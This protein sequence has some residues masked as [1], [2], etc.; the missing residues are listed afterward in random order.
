LVSC[1]G[2]S[3]TNSQISS[4]NALISNVQSTTAESVKPSAKSVLLRGR[5]I[6]TTKGYVFGNEQIVLVFI[7]RVDGNFAAVAEVS[8][9]G[10]FQ[11][12]ITVGNYTLTL[13][14]ADGIP[15]AGNPELIV[16]VS[17]TSPVQ[18]EID[19]DTETRKITII[20][21]EGCKVSKLQLLDQD[22]D[23][24]P[25]K[26]ENKLDSNGDGKLDLVE[27][28]IKE[29]NQIAY[30]QQQTQGTVNYLDEREIQENWYSYLHSDSYPVMSID[31][32]I[33]KYPCHIVVEIDNSIPESDKNFVLKY[34][35]KLCSVLRYLTNYDP[36]VS[37]I[38]SYD[39]GMHRSWNNNLTHLY[40]SVL[41]TEDPFFKSWYSVELAHL[42]IVHK[43]FVNKQNN[44]WLYLRPNET[45]SQ[46]LTSVVA[47]YYGKQL[48]FS[49]E[50]YKYY[51]QQLKPDFYYAIDN[52]IRNTNPF[53]IYQTDVN[54][55]MNADT[56]SASA[57]QILT[58]FLADPNFFKNL[59]GTS[60][61]WSS[62]ADLKSDF[63]RSVETLPYDVLSAYVNNMP[64]FKQ[65]DQS[66]RPK[67]MISVVLR[68]STDTKSEEGY[69]RFGYCNIDSFA[70]LG[71]SYESDNLEKPPYEIKPDPNFYGHSVKLEI[72]D[73]SKNKI[74][75]SFN[76]KIL[77][78]LD[79]GGWIYYK[80]EPG[81]IYRIIATTT[82]DGVN[83]TDRRD[84]IANTCLKA[85][86]QVA[87]MDEPI[88]FSVMTKVKF[89]QYYWDFDG[90]DSIDEITKENTISYSYHQVGIYH[91]KVGI[92]FENGK[93][94]WLDMPPVII[95]E[96]L[97]LE[98]GNV[99]NEN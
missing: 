86:K 45:L 80:F 42:Y 13:F 3:S 46:T 9:D 56:L 25:D 95:R 1:G 22:G 6:S 4:Q 93:I 65:L 10:T 21:K 15:I 44:D 66:K 23:F 98:K 32:V 58:L 26:V 43:N 8:N 92:S 64:Y 34:H 41:P 40:A 31:E 74:V 38:M 73:L 78:N 35:A 62:G 61:S 71:E 96:Q 16:S 59:L 47:Y 97:L 5:I 69:G 79:N 14:N 12:E 36:H 39:P 94:F 83:Y 19:L 7:A 68:S 76:S 51:S 48:G 20:P 67:R 57:H 88:T 77:S 50:E 52:F 29:H 49:D 87:R 11:K 70:V 53:I 54:Y 55:D 27:K 28:W 30:Q 60:F 85:N 91:P 24:I 17:G 18:V 81:N 84:F 82:I 33:K 89:R 63:I 37:F 72:L 90:D 99:E 2:G 75:K